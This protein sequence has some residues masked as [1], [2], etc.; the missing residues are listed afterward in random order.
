MKCHAL[1]KGRKEIVNYFWWYSI[2]FLDLWTCDLKINRDHILI[3]GNPCTKFGI[4]QIK[5]SKDT[6]R[7]RLVY[8]PT[9]RHTDRHTSTDR[10]TDRHTCSYRHNDRSTFAKQYAPF[11]KGA[12][13][14]IIEYRQKYLIICFLHLKRAWHFSKVWL[15]PASSRILKMF[16]MILYY[17]PFV[18]FISSWKRV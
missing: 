10:H 5:G 11:F 1:F 9:D 14:S 16:S 7:T 2:M 17:L 18:T 4:D 8:R 3:E 15:K 13:K 12:L 6:E